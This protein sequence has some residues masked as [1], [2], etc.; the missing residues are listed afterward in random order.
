MRSTVFSHVIYLNVTTL[1][2]YGNVTMNYEI[3]KVLVTSFSLLPSLASNHFS[4]STIF[5]AFY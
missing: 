1:Q 5:S 3:M 4:S 2:N